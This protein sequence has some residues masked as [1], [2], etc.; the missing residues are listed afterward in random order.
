MT[1]LSTL[2]DQIDNNTILLPELQR[3]YV[4]NRNQVRGLMRSLY[5]R[6]PVGSLLVWQTPADRAATRGDGQALPGYVD[7]LLDGQQR[8]TTLYG[9]IRGQP[10]EFFEGKPETFTGLFFS[11]DDETFEFYGPSKM[12]G[13]PRWIDVS[14][15]MASGI[16]PYIESIGRDGDLAP[17]LATYIQRLN[18]LHGIY[19]IDFH[20]ERITGADKSLDVVVE[21]FDRVNSGG[22]KL[23]KADLALSKLCAEWPDARQSLRSSVG[24]WNDKGFKF[25][26]DWFLRVVNAV[27]TGEAKFEMLEGVSSEQFQDGVK[28]AVRAVDTLLNNIGAHLGIDHDR[29]LASKFS[30]AALAR[31]IDTNGGRFTDAAERDLALYWY[32]H[33]VMWGRYSASS[34]SVLNQDIEFLEQGGLPA[35][36]EGMARWRGDLTVRPTDFASW[37][38]GS[39]FYPILYV[40]SRVQGAR[41][42][43]NGSPTLSNAML[44]KLSGLQVHHI[45]PKRRLYDAGYDRPQVNSVANYCFLT[46]DT[47]LWVSDRD[48]VEYFAAVEEAYPGALASQWIPMDESLWSTD[49]YLDFLEARRELLAA[50]T[51]ELLSSLQ[52][53]AAPDVEL[54]AI[55]PV[56]EN[57]KDD[58]ER[59][60]SDLVEWLERQGYATPELD[61]EIVDED[62]GEVICVAEAVWRDGLQVGIGDPVV[63]ELDELTVESEAKLAALGFAAFPTPESLKTY[64]ERVEAR[65]SASDQSA[66]L[67]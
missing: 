2:L 30:L 61:S 50:A 43:W 27:T 67:A 45:F 44:G 51:N 62:T 10:P 58:I 37:S 57:D 15:L 21:I 18:D 9:I 52:S 40:L 47:N 4:W 1:K 36:I 31:H 16:G 26:L 63:L 55:G 25:T 13:N 53:G 64:V 19:E 12:K 54:E 46:Q 38:L 23:S 65:S 5:R 48:P 49:R 59:A 41:D 66:G 17:N 6:Y 42:W 35:L 24:V 39:R 22:T 20:I 60:I 8:L 56:V 3:G 32:L 7:L 34:E 28:R 14:G 33:S 29:V 11:L